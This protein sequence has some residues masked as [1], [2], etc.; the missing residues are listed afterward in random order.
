MRDVAREYRN[1]GYEV[2]MHPSGT[3][4]PSFLKDFQPDLLAVSEAESVVVEVK[5][6]ADLTSASELSLLAARISEQPGWRLELVVTNPRGTRTELAD[7]HTLWQRIVTSRQLAMQGHA[8]AAFLLMWTATE[9]VL[10]IIADRED[11][12]VDRLPPAAIVRRLSILGLVDRDDYRTL[13]E[14]AQLRNTL[15]HGFS[16]R[17]VDA[18]LLQNV[19][20]VTERLLEACA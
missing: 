2:R 16:S 12:S 14:A 11:V 9:A 10:R 1:A 7:P 4:L 13:E 20:G 15:V 19:G 3:D 17:E 5:S 6:Q 18:H 8:E